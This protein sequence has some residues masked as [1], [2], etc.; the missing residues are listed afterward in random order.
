MYRWLLLLF[1]TFSLTGVSADE[2]IPDVTN[3]TAID[4]PSE[5]EEEDEESAD[6]TIIIAGLNS[7][8]HHQYLKI[9]YPNS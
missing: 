8:N 4:S 1:L 5:E 9:P 7:I 3:E 6:I 2:H